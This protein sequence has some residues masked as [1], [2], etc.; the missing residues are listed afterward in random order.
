[1]CSYY[2]PKKSVYIAVRG[3]WQIENKNLAERF[4]I[5]FVGCKQFTERIVI[6]YVYI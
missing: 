3:K 2:T 6:F 1:M 5:P 4:K